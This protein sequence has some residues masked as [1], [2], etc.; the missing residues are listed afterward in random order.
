VLSF[1]L[2]VYSKEVNCLITLRSTVVNVVQDKYLMMNQVIFQVP[3]LMS[4]L[5]D[6]LCQL[7]INAKQK[8]NMDVMSILGNVNGTTISFAL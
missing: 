2:E 1:K 8:A 3:V 5:K 7:L 4:I 6:K